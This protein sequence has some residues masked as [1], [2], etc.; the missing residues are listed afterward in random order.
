MLGELNLQKDHFCRL[1][2]Y[3]NYPKNTTKGTSEIFGSNET[4]FRCQKDKCQDR[5]G[6]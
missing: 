4:N 2:R 6:S 5:Q 3:K 1:F